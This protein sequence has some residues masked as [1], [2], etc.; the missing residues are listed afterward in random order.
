MV[1]TVYRSA[2]PAVGRL[3]LRRWWRLPGCEL[4][5]AATTCRSV[6]GGPLVAAGGASVG[7]EVYRLAELN[8]VV[9]G[10]VAVTVGL[11][12][13]RGRSMR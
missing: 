6:D 9:E 12:H 5:A 4:G 7:P 11:A 8:D 1:I 13:Q 3:G 10:L 2:R